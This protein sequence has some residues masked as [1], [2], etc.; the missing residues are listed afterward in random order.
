MK[1]VFIYIFVIVFWNAVDK[2]YRGREGAMYNTN[3]EK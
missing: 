3:V 2:Y 1:I